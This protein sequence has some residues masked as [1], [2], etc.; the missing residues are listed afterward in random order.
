MAVHSYHRYSNEAERHLWWS[1]IKKNVGLYDLYINNSWS[2][3]WVDPVSDCMLYHV[4]VE[5]GIIWVE[6]FVGKANNLN[7]RM[8]FN[9]LILDISCERPTW[10]TSWSTHSSHV[11]ANQN[12]VS[13]YCLMPCAILSTSFLSVVPYYILWVGIHADGPVKLLNLG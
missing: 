9:I 11:L 5:Y 3:L 12:T 7:V 2:A 1:Q 6:H 8:R 13:R 4:H 10:N